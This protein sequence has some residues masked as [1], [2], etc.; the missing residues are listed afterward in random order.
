MLHN[1]CVTYVTMCHSLCVSQ[2]YQYMCHNLYSDNVA[3]LGDPQ[4]INAE[5]KKTQSF[6]ML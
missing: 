4:L 6:R 1:L 2:D 5:L 3:G